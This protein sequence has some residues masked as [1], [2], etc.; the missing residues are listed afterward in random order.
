MSASFRLTRS[1]SP[2]RCATDIWSTN[3]PPPPAL[4]EFL[5]TVEADRFPQDIGV[6]FR[7]LDPAAERALEDQFG[8]YI[9]G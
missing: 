7:L 9:C 8:E 3:G 5:K 1:D 2:D 4:R 6:R